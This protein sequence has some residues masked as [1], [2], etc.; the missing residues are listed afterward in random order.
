MKKVYYAILHEENGGY[1]SEVPDLPNC[2]SQDDT[3][4]ETII[5]MRN[6][7]QGLVDIYAEDKTP[8]PPPRSFLELVK[9]YPNKSLVPIEIVEPRANE[10]INISAP[11]HYLEMITRAAKRRKMTR[12]QFMVSAALKEAESVHV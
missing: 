11:G 10:R 5:G 7:A 9:E 1:W 6:A 4:E 12:S 3:P 8:I 2:V